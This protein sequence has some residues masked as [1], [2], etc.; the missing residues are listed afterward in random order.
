MCDRLLLIN[1]SVLIVRDRPL[2]S[3]LS[4]ELTPNQASKV[5]SCEEST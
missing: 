1:K 5:V 3:R 2:R 4:I